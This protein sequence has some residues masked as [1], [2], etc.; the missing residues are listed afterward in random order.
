MRTIETKLYK[1]T[2]LS[3]EAQERARNDRRSASWYGDAWEGEWRDTLKHAADAFSVE[4]G[5]WSV[6]LY[7][8]SYASLRVR[9][10]AVAELEGVRAWKY[11]RANY[12]DAI[13]ERGSCPF[14][15]YCG[16]EDLLDPLRN[17]LERPNTTNTVQDI[18]DECAHAWA[19]AWRADME[20]QH[21]DEYVAEDL[22]D[23]DY[24]FTEDGE[25][26]R[27]H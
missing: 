22:T 23:N 17:F 9:D 12:A 15:G 13:G 8:P 10:E 2:E 27:G 20:Y 25:L 4:A 6:G 7:Q 16:D 24:E 14:T 18:L 3:E 21:S 19:T 5:D 11:L 26:Y 1:Y